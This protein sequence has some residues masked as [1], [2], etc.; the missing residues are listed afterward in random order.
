MLDAPI[1]DRSTMRSASAL[2]AVILTL[3]L[4]PAGASAQTM[5]DGFVSMYEVPYGLGETGELDSAVA[6]TRDG[7]LNKVV[8][9]SPRWMLSTTAI[10]NLVN[11]VTQ[12]SNNTIVVNASQINR[13]VQQAVTALPRGSLPGASGAVADSAS[14]VSLP[15]AAVQSAQR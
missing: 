13:G 9:A 7:A 15:S 10:G 5:E 3:G 4:L 8:T 6:A 11:V 12:G 1:N 2:L 14:S